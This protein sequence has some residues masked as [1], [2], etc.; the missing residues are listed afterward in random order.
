M[1]VH[2]Q[3]NLRIPEPFEESAD[4]RRGHDNV[5]HPGRQNQQD[6]LRLRC[7]RQWLELTQMDTAASRRKKRSSISYA[8]TA[9]D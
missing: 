6:A 8:A 2:D 9:N 5:S 3:G 7:K 4:E 1:A